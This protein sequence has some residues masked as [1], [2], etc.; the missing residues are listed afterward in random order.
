MNKYLIRGTAFTVVGI[1]CLYYGINLMK[2][3]LTDNL[4]YKILLIAG[5]LS[6]GY[7]FITLIYRMFRKIDRN[8]II[9]H[10]K[11]NKKQNN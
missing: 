1:L 5:V 8:T 6:F 2:S 4:W 9:D 10:R 7:G 11:S 3:D